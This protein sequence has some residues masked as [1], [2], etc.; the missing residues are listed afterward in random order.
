MSGPLRLTSLRHSGGSTFP[1]WLSGSW[2]LISPLGLLFTARIAWEK[3]VLT[4]SRGPQAVGFSLMHVHPAFAVLGSLCSFL[5][6]VWSVPGS[7]YLIRRWKS[8][9][10]IDK[11][12]VFVSLLASIF[13]IL[14][15]TFF[16]ASHA[17][18]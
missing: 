12:M 15:D 16:V 14:P 18:P 11:A 6:I 8:S 1:N 10:L 4:W 5:L 13:L 9:S 7:I 3:T 2:L 17:G